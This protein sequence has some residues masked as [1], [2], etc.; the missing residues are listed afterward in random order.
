MPAIYYSNKIKDVNKKLQSIYIYIYIHKQ[1]K[2]ELSHPY[3]SIEVL[4][5]LVVL[6]LL[7]PSHQPSLGS[8]SEVALCL[9]KREKEK[10]KNT[11][12]IYK[13]FFFGLIEEK[14]EKSMTSKKKLKFSLL[15]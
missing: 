4:P 11:D 9:M 6:N 15:F 10:T 14:R 8:I 13:L 2:R 3:V 7:N 1:K 12:N 5:Q